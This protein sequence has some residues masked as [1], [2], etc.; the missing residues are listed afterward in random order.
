[1]GKLI[2]IL[3][4]LAIG[5]S[6]FLFRVLLPLIDRLV[7]N[8][9]CFRAIANAVDG[10]LT[11]NPWLSNYTVHFEHE[12]I[13]ATFS[14]AQTSGV[15]EIAWPDASFRMNV[16]PETVLSM[17]G[18]WVGVQDIKVGSKM[19][20]QIFVLQSNRPE[21]LKKV[22]SCDLVQSEIRELRML[23]R[24]AEFNMTISAGRL[25]IR[26]PLRFNKHHECV[27]FVKRC[28]NLYSLLWD[29]TEIHFVASRTS[30]SVK[31]I[32]IGDA[33]GI[34]LVCGQKL[35]ANVV[36]C[37]KCKTRHHRDCWNYIGNCSIFGCGE[38]RFR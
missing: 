7:A 37:R 19:F 3:I 1:M 11:G 31:T 23:A 13:P 29:D 15:L 38:S 12:G 35:V 17:I 22:L 4:F 25:T 27:E 32:E 5:C 36:S 2:V 8:K 30:E 21:E 34:C 16:F 14:Q 9:I 10:R 18:K 6:V 33:E 26:K 28:S 20:D 24:N